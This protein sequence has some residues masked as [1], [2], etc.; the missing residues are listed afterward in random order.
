MTPYRLILKWRNG[1]SK[2]YKCDKSENPLDADLLYL[3][4]KDDDIVSATSDS[5]IN[6]WSSAR[7]VR[8]TL[9]WV[10][11]RNPYC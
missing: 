6:T 4:V 7:T 9:K 11:E 1:K 10:N 2:S 8:R 5:G 3:I